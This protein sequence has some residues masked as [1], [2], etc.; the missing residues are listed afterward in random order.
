[1]IIGVDSEI[2]LKE[3]FFYM[4]RPKLK[5]NEIKEINKLLNVSSDVI[6]PRRWY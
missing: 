2:Q 6:D 1:M 4:S 5:K 3:L